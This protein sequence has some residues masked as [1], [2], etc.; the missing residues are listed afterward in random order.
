MNNM[1]TEP[2]VTMINQITIYILVSKKKYNHNSASLS[3]RSHGDHRHGIWSQ[4]HLLWVLPFGSSGEIP[5]RQLGTIQRL[6]CTAGGLGCLSVDKHFLEVSVIS[7]TQFSRPWQQFYHQLTA[8]Q[9]SRHGSPRRRSLCR[10][11]GL[12]FWRSTCKTKRTFIWRTED[13]DHSQKFRNFTFNFLSQHDKLVVQTLV[14]HL[15][16]L[17]Q[18]LN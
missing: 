16:L 2:W 9:Q 5:G 8:R 4:W 7:V 12:E 14:K 6:T 10:I 13:I 1:V 3:S 18:T 17:I 11:P 15:L